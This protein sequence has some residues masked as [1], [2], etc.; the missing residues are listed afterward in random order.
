MKSCG[1]KDSFRVCTELRVWYGSMEAY[2]PVVMHVGWEFIRL[3]VSRPLQTVGWNPG[4]AAF[5]WASKIHKHTPGLSYSV[6]VSGNFQRHAI[7]ASVQVTALWP[8]KPT[9]EQEILQVLASTARAWHH[10]T[11]RL[12]RTDLLDGGRVPPSFFPVG[13]FF[14]FVTDTDRKLSAHCQSP[15]L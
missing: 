12:I 9:S 6:F 15:T 10:A 5:L 13:Y 3:L 7:E 2:Y 14:Q 8:G 4:S 1:R 11:C